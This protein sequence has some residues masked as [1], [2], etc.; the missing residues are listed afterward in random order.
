MSILIKIGSIAG[1]LMAIAGVWHLFEMP[2]PAWSSDIQ[3][4]NN[5]QANIAVE[6]YNQKLRNYLVSTPPADPAAKQIW[7]EDL[8]QARQQRDDAEKRRIELSK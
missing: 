7:E 8:R 4:L 3:K 5:N 6:L 1:A 2:T